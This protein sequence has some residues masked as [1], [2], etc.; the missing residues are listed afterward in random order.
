MITNTVNQLE[1][2][3]NSKDKCGASCKV[4]K[5]EFHDEKKEVK[6][7]RV[8][9]LRQLLCWCCFQKQ[10]VHGVTGLQLEDRTD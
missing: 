4:Y 7:E 5:N 10:N 1:N 6:I 2:N 8:H 3:T 9:H